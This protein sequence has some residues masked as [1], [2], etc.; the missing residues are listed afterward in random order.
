[1]TASNKTEP[2]QA[3]DAYT[4]HVANKDDNDAGQTSPRGRRLL[5]KDLSAVLD[6]EESSNDSQPLKIKLTLPPGFRKR[7]E[8]TVSSASRPPKSVPATKRGRPRKTKSTIDGDDYEPPRGCKSA[9]TTVTT[10]TTVHTSSAPSRQ[11][12]DHH[13]IQ[14]HHP[15]PDHRGKP[16][17]PVFVP[18]SLLSSDDLSGSEDS[19]LTDEETDEDRYPE[20]TLV[21]DHQLAHDRARTNR[22]LLGNDDALVPTRAPRKYKRHTNSKRHTPTVND[23]L[24]GSRSS[25]NEED[26]EKTDEEDEDEDDEADGDAD[27]PTPMQ[28][29][30]LSDDE[31]EKLDAQLF[32]SNLLAETS[33][34]EDE[35]A[36]TDRDSVMGD[37][38]LGHEG[39]DTD[40]DVEVGQFEQP[41]MVKEGW[42]GELVF[43]T[44]ILPPPGALDFAFEA[45]VSQVEDA[46]QTD[47]LANSLSTLPVMQPATVSDED[48][49]L[50]EIV[51]EAGD[52]TDDEIMPPSLIP[53]PFTASIAPQA[54]FTPHKTPMNLHSMSSSFPSP[55]P[56]D[57]L[58]GHLPWDVV[59]SPIHSIAATDEPPPRS[60]SLSIHSV[61]SGSRGPKL[62]Y[63]N[64]SN[65]GNKRTIIGDTNNSKLPSPFS[66]LTP[67]APTFRRKRRANVS[68]FPPP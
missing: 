58:A 51:S 45:D 60:R 55:S 4:H 48:E 50:E 2:M 61:G 10:T 57:V 5:P 3:P 23:D 31:D 7:P 1:M 9:R 33:G 64:G 30:P 63:F 6:A 20:E 40:T 18:A 49:E 44:E 68:A 35:D 19:K 41:L 66:V 39:S 26:D 67:P 12:H 43:S 52:T 28:V 54:T 53:L 37:I 42:D 38:A 36:A 65:F 17:F 25:G 46:S 56:A 11:P 14:A 62:G 47:S 15:S 27:H 32:F 13:N 59:A 21:I 22:E 34:S 24:D 16:R 29:D 8:E